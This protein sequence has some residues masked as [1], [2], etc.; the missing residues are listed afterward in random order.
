M[1]INKILENPKFTYN[2]ETLR[3]GIEKKGKSEH[4]FNDP[5]NLRHEKLIKCFIP[6]PSRHSFFSSS[7]IKIV[8][9]NDVI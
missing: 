6:S 1:W 8:V 2:E 4:T 7:D 5:L 3:K 9:I